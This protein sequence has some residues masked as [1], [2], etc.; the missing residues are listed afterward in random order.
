MSHTDDPILTSREAAHLLGVAVSTTQ[1]WMESGA[2]QAWKT[3][4]GHRRVRLSDVLRLRRQRE[5]DGEGD[6]MYDPAGGLADSEDAGEFVAAAAPSYPVPAG[7]QARLAA[8]AGSGLLDTP[9]EEAFDRL[10]RLAAQ[11]TDCP[12]AMVTLLSA[13]RQWFKAR[14][15]IDAAETPREWAFCSHA[16]ASGDTLVVIDAASDTRFASNPMVTG[17]PH[18]R[19]YAGVPLEDAQGHLLGALCVL[20]REPRRLREREL[21]ALHELAAIASDEIKR[22]G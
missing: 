21:R 12:I 8:L 1:I 4:G 2:L 10:A 19:F 14:V 15:G 16:L 7:E 9:P 5:A 18:V 6:P 20:D 17:E 3:P 22:R 13:R 11:V